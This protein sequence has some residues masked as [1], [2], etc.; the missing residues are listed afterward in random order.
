MNLCNVVGERVQLSFPE[1]MTSGMTNQV[2]STSGSALSGQTFAL[3]LWAAKQIQS[4]TSFRLWYVK[5]VLRGERELRFVPALTDPKRTSLDI[6]ANRGLYALA[7][8]H[9][10]KKVIAFEPQPQFA[11]FLR[12]YFSGNV[13][14]RECAVSDATGFANLLIP[15]DPRFHAE[16]RLSP[17]F[18]N[19]G[20]SGSHIPVSVS[21]VRLDDE[22]H[23]D[24]GFMK[25]DVEGHELSVLE[26]AKKLIEK[27]RPNIIVE[28]EN[29]HRPGALADASQWF[30]AKGYEGFYLKK[31]VLVPANAIGREQNDVPYNFI[32]LPN[33]RPPTIRGSVVAALRG[34]FEL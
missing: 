22:I 16:A 31:D 13:D 6:G 27:C 18:G 28:I 25:I 30:K 7:A 4:R 8:L 1:P 33:E 17:P 34:V 14:V 15:A 2:H 23:D 32:F 3:K 9:W 24:V 26:G 11:A 21:T 10:S 5:Q 19:P 20:L 12:R 29:R